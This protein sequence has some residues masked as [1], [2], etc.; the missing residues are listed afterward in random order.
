M[1]KHERILE[2]RRIFKQEFL[3]PLAALMHYGL[4]IK[5]KRIEEGLRDDHAEGLLIEKLSLQSEAFHDFLQSHEYN[6]LHKVARLLDE[7]L[8]DI[9]AVIGELRRHYEI[10]KEGPELFDALP[11][12]IKRMRDEIEK[13]KAFERRN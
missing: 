6:H 11:I 1:K 4:K 9:R 7:K 13:F 5:A 8:T 10:R 12:A 3:R 2:R